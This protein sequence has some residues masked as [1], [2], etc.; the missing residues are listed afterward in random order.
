M[1]G[2]DA[3][4]AIRRCDPHAR[5]VVLTVRQGSEDIYRV[6]QAGAT[7]YLFKDMLSRD[8]IRTI[9]QVHQ[10]DRTLPHVVAARL[11][12]RAAAPMLTAREVEVL[13]FV[14]EGLTNKDI[15]LAMSIS[16]ATVHAHL[17]SVFLKLS[18][19]DRFAAVRKATRRG[20]I[21]LQ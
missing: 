13:E 19:D 14:A 12:E 5:I 4:G 7:T 16:D 21:H 1:S 11:T 3:I 10:G 15:G 6:L 20:I 2:L 18:V 9:R 8:L 17:K